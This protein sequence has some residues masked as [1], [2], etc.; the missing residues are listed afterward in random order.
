MDSPEIINLK[1]PR[2]WFEQFDQGGGLP[3]DDEME[4]FA[5][6]LA[7]ELIEEIPGVPGEDFRIVYF[8]VNHEGYGSKPTAGDWDIT[9][10]MI[11]RALHNS[12]G[13]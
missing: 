2:V 8:V 6:A 9:P 7:D 13:I 3:T 10:E 12:L 5:S 11:N 4:S 1:V